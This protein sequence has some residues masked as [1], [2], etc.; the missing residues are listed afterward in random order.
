MHYA[1][2]V[3]WQWN[4]RSLLPVTFGS[5]H[6]V[7]LFTP[8]P[9]AQAIDLQYKRDERAAMMTEA[10]ATGMRHATMSAVDRQS[11]M[12]YIDHAK[13]CEKSLL[14][15]P[16]EHRLLGMDDYLPPHNG[17]QESTSGSTSLPKWRVQTSY[18]W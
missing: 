18:D 4:N 3:L 5:Q 14:S 6:H 2:N 11:E 10:I 1:H 16:L 9:E 13:T 8:D 7:D 17:G 12:A 15:A